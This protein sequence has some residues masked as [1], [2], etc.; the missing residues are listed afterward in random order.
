MWRPLFLELDAIATYD[1]EW[2]SIRCIESC[3][4]DD[5]VKINV[6]S[7]FGVDA[8]WSDAGDGRIDQ[9]IL[10]RQ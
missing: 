1:R 7:V 3:C 4:T 2:E 6:L 10:A 5:D 8:V 9:V